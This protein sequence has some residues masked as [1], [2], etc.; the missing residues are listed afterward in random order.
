MYDFEKSKWRTVYSV[1]KYLWTTYC[2]LRSCPMIWDDS[3][4]QRKGSFSMKGWK[5]CLIFSPE[6][7]ERFS[8]KHWAKATLFR[9]SHEFSWDRRSWGLTCFSLEFQTQR[10]QISCYNILPSQGR[11][12]GVP[13]PWDRH[14]LFPFFRVL[15]SLLLLCGPLLLG[16]HNGHGKDSLLPK[17]KK[18][19]PN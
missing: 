1:N 7:T 4:I 2:M 12:A 9:N 3:S 11:P 8:L 18:K 10:P 15:E 13:C 14:Q 5:V 6:F 19:E 17:V 16:N